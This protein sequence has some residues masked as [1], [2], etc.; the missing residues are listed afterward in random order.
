MSVKIKKGVKPKYTRNPTLKIY[1]NLNSEG[2]T[3]L[4]SCQTSRMELLEKI[5]N[6][7]YSLNIFG[8]KHYYRCLEGS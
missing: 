7:F 2:K 3:Y 5:V 6:T 8:K 4:G 1:S